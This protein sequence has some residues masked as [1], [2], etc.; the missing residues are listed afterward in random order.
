MKK[1]ILISVFAS[2]CISAP[3]LAAPLGKA[4]DLSSVPATRSFDLGEKSNVYVPVARKINAD[5]R[6]EFRGNPLRNPL[7]Y[8]PFQRIPH[9]SH[10]DLLWGTQPDTVPIATVADW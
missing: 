5:A 3:V 6:R 4:N 1:Q 8:S 10:E 7:T 9:G 2:F